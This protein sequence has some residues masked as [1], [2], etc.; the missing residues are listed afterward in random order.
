MLATLG[1]LFA[2]SGIV[3]ILP[4]V[5]VALAVLGWLLLWPK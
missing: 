2:V 5:I 1:V 4:L 3:W